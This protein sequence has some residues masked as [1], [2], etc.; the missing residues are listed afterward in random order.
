MAL[1]YG[2]MSAT[3]LSVVIGSK[4]IVAPS[5]AL[6]FR[7]VMLS[8]AAL[9]A[10]FWFASLS[11][12]LFIGYVYPSNSPSAKRVSSTLTTA[13]SMS[14]SVSPI[15]FLPFGAAVSFA[16]NAASVALRAARWRTDER[17]M[18][19]QFVSVPAWSEIVAVRASIICSSSVALAYGA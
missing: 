9:S 12:V 16:L 10:S 19:S 13:V 14:A 11:N 18:N 5:G 8:C 2:P 4:G 15:Y 6:F 3:F 7:S 17:L 1:A